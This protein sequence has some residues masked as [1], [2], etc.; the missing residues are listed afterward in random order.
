MSTTSLVD[1]GVFRKFKHFF[2]KM[3]TIKSVQTNAKDMIQTN[4]T[5]SASHTYCFVRI[6][7]I[8]VCIMY[9][10]YE[11]WLNVAR[12][13]LVSIVCSIHSACVPYVTGVFHT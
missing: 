4:T 13:L 8:C 12:T 11:A 5:L 7:H 3:F 2:Q 6:L 1:T 10:V 9:I